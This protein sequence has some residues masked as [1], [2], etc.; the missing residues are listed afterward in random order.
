MCVYVS[1]VR[2][3]VTLC[4]YVLRVRLCVTISFIKVTT[5][6][7]FAQR[8]ISKCLTRVAGLLGELLK[9]IVPFP[10]AW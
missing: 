1:H 8:L 6:N 4:V 7:V 5:E 10:F 3:C 2:L 9:K